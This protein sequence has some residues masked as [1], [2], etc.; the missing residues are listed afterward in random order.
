MK[1]AFAKKF[2]Q[3]GVLL[4]LYLRKQAND[5]QTSALIRLLASFCRAHP[6]RRNAGSDYADE[7]S[8]VTALFLAEYCE[9]HGGFLLFGEFS[10][11]QL[12]SHL[13]SR[14]RNFTL[15]LL[16][17]SR[18]KLVSL[19]K[20]V[21]RPA[22]GFRRIKNLLVGR[23]SDFAAD[24]PSIKSEGTLLSLWQQIKGPA[25]NSRGQPVLKDTVRVV[26]QMFE[27]AGGYLTKK[28][29][30]RGF[31]MLTGFNEATEIP[32][33]PQV[34]SEAATIGIDDLCPDADANFN[35][36]Q[37]AAMLQQTA[38]RYGPA[39]KDFVDGL[40]PEWQTI[41]DGMLIMRQNNVE[42]AGR[43][44]ISPQG[45]GKAFRKMLARLFDI[46]QE[47]DETDRKGFLC[48]LEQALGE[49]KKTQMQGAGACLNQRQ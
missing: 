23:S 6:L 19:V 10:H 5:S 41:L 34:H 46:L 25:L 27:I 12:A 49:S 32:F 14:Y 42:V 13:I 37:L 47:L 31:E 40:S 2:E 1:D 22:N 48:A 15:T 24:R 7:R 38:L 33:Q 30:Y 28:I 17:E 26:S 4:D 36:V 39:A 8:Q 29:F 9:K 45:C 18:Q 16:S 21:V 43:A 20:A 44:G 3:I 11:V 35:Q